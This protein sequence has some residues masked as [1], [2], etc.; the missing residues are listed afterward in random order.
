MWVVKLGGSLN[1]DPLLPE[2]LDLLGQ[3]GGGRV[4]IVCGGGSFADE[5]RRAHPD[6][7]SITAAGEPRRH[8]AR[9]CMP[10]RSSAS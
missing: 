5:V 3:L 2:W 8:W 1:A 4:T 7:I 6:W 10:E 9:R